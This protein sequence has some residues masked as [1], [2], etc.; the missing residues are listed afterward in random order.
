MLNETEWLKLLCE[1]GVR[2]TT[3]SNWAPIFARVI[4]ESTFSAGRDDIGP[5]IGQ[6]LH[7][8]GMLERLEESLNYSAQRMTEVW[9]KRFPT[10]ESALPYA[11]N[12]PALANK[13]Y[14]G[15]LGNVA[16]GDGWKYRGRGLIMVTG[17]DNYSHVGVVLG[18]DLENNP[19]LLAQPEIAL[20]SAIAWWEGKI[21]DG[22]LGDIKKVT[23]RVN[24]GTVGLAHRQDMTEKAREGLA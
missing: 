3:A 8:S 17:R 9:D 12:A 10:V 11:H 19:D 20:R 21:P 18:L 22:I 14:G 6:V 24:G 1:C 5:F 15:R 13:V 23:K 16:P 7:E 2:A 4:D